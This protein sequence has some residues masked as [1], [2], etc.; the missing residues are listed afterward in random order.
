MIEIL[1]IGGLLAWTMMAYQDKPVSSLKQTPGTTQ[2]MVNLVDNGFQF[3]D[4]MFSTMAD[5]IGHPDVK[6]N[7]FAHQSARN[8]I[9]DPG[10]YGVHRSTLQLY[11][12]V[13]EP[14]QIYRQNN[15]VL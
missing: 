7:Y 1:A 9:N 8:T 10:I 12:G 13:S 15:L 14:V 11:D 5:W 6:N 2:R 4:N 3:R